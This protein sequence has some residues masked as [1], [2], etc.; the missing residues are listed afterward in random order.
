MAKLTRDAARDIL[1]RCHANVRH[2]FH[3]LH[4]DV[5]HALL[6]E[7][8]AV[9]YRQPKNANGSRAR[10]FHARLVRAAERKD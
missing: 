4:S 2:D 5:V 3:S 10:Y 8:D 1:A 6:R 7:A 9:G